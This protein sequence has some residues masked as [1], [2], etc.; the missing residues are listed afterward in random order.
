MKEKKFQLGLLPKLII[1]VIA[2]I[3]IGTFAPEV[4]MR[5]VIT[6]IDIFGNY[7]NFIVPL[8]ILAFVVTG[9]SDLGSGSGKIL[10]FSVFMSYGSTVLWELWHI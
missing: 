3:I 2:G 8:I 4:L 5:G 7:L 1:G 6:V 9:I 10:G